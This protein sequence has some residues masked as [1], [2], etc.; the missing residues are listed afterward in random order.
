MYPATAESVEGAPAGT[1][2]ARGPWR[3][4]LGRFRR[5]RVGV[6]ALGILLAF[7]IVG[8]LAKTIAPYAADDEFIQFLAHPQ[9]PLTAHH[10]LGTD[11]ISH[12]FLSQL[13]VSVHETVLSALVCAGCTTVVGTIV[14]ALAAYYGGWF[15]AAVSWLTTVIVAVPAIAFLLVVIIWSRFPVSPIQFAYWLTLVLWTGVA[16]VVR[17]HVA[18]LRVREYVEAAHA[19]GASGGRIIARHLLPNATGTVL[20][21]ATSV[22]GQSIVLVA[23]IDYLGFG[24]NEYSRPTLGGLLANAARGTAAI[25]GTFLP[26]PSP[27]WLFVFPAVLL[28]LLLVC[29]NVVGDALDDALN[30]RAA[31]G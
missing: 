26:A 6:A 9:P 20:V 13:L 3:Q 21:A 8:L 29:I 15:D 30:P 27:W 10:L 11:A 7:G 2:F 24:F 19:L 31:I 16:R 28:V 1:A 5:R 18:S 25:P 22:M 12:D 14:G 17:A 4:A 23:T